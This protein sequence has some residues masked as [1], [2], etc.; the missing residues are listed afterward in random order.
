LKSSSSA[1]P[2]GEIQLKLAFDPHKHGYHFSN[3][4]IKWSWGPISGTALCGGMAYSAIDYWTAGMSLPQ[5]EDV[6]QQ[7]DAVHQVIYDRQ[8]D[9]HGNTVLRFGTCWMNNVSSE[10]EWDILD[11]WIRVGQP[12]PV[13]LFRDWSGHHTVA[14]GIDL[15]KRSFDLYDPNYPSRPCTITQVPGGFK[16]S[17]ESTP[18]RGFFVDVRYE[19]KRPP[20]LEGEFRWKRCF[21]STSPAT[22]R[23]ARIPAALTILTAAPPMC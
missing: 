4:F 11:G 6:P 16:H 8:F 18:W 9:A 3:G 15:T 1:S 21:C 5:Q 17:N 2:A 19:Y 14:Y 22:T 20:L 10:A 7:G 23:P 13:C 12:M